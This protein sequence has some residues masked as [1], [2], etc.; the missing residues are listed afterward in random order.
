MV[1]GSV[2]AIYYGEP[3]MLQF[4]KEGGSG[5]HL[6]DINRMVV[7]LGAAWDRGDLEEMIYKYS[8]G[9]EWQMAT[10]ADHC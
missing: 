4:F 3:R 9:S 6:R 1:S 5:K 7:S 10:A 2:A 8:L